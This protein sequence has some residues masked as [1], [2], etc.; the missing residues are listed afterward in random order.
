MHFKR[1][2][3]RAKEKAKEEKAENEETAANQEKAVARVDRRGNRLPVGALSARVSTGPPNAPKCY[4]EG[5]AQSGR[6]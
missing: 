5:T 1:A 4:E 3:V 2:K 6:A